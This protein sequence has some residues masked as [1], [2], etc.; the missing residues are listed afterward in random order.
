MA[1]PDCV[2]CGK[3]AHYSYKSLEDK[4]LYKTAAWGVYLAH[5]YGSS[6]LRCLRCVGTENCV[7]CG[8]ELGKVCAL[9]DG[10]DDVRSCF[11]GTEFCVDCVTQE[12][13]RS[14][15]KSSA[16][17]ASKRETNNRL[18]RF[19]FFAFPVL[20]I[21]MLQFRGGDPNLEWWVLGMGAGWVMTIIAYLTSK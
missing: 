12:L 10:K 9:S 4:G 3:P 20:A 1:S 11:C 13:S 17:Q 5:R 19:F 16:L 18:F 7:S 21:L 8:K 15:S 6:R 14:P 2:T